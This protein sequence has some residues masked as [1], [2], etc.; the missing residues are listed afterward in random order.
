MLFCLGVLYCYVELLVELELVALIL[1]VCLNLFV[2][3]FYPCFKAF[4]CSYFLIKSL[5]PYVILSESFSV[6][7][8]EEIVLIRQ[9]V[10]R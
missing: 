8:H 3:H 2:N 9:N 10:G 1:V 6:G 7:L 5:K 4:F